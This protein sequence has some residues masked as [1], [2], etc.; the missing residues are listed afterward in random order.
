MLYGFAFIIAGLAIL[1]YLEKIF[2][3][4][5]LP[6]VKNWYSRVLSINL[7]QLLI[8]II[9]AYTWETYFEGNFPTILSLKDLVRPSLGGF[10]AYLVN[11]YIFYWFHR[12]RHEIYLLW[13][14]LH[15]VHHSAARI[16]TIT[17]FY[18][19]PLEILVD[20]LL[21]TILL[22]PVLG[23]SSESSI[24]L[25]IFSAYGEYFY[26]MNIRTP[27]MIGYF[28]QRPESHRIHHMKNKR[29]NCKNYSDFPL[30]D[31]LGNTFD[32]PEI[33]TVPTGFSEENENKLVDMLLFKDVLYSKV[34]N[35]NTKKDM[36]INCTNFLALILL[37][38]G[39]LQPIGY[40]F[41]QQDIK[42]LGIITVSSPLPLVFSAY[43]GVETFRTSFTV[44]LNYELKDTSSVNCFTKVSL[45]NNSSVNCFTKS[46]NLTKEIYSNIE[47][48][49][50]RHNVF[51]VLFSH[52]PFFTSEKLLTLRNTLLRY[53]VCKDQLNLHK[54]VLEESDEYELKSFNIRI[55]LRD[56]NKTWNLGLDCI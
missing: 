5:D 40:L 6:V 43:N 26:H 22:F 37:L 24:Y 52:G 15:Q 11:T 34:N 23:L 16:E 18:K 44:D 33:D 20:S 31:M 2:P 29:K 19:H 17:S 54:D 4:R 51:N 49:Y 13:I 32:N 35:N 21:M 56:S 10:I 50:N 25:S 48:P 9:G 36:G 53:V 47:G 45:V 27:H 1:V 55:N 42:N 14:L 3:D 30:W 39:L 28:F 38:T 7:A 8:V 46:I 41:N 12:A